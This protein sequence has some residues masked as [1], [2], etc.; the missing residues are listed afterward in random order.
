[1][2]INKEKKA[3]LL[4]LISTLF[5]KGIAFLTVPI[6]TRLLTTSD[7]GVTT[8][9]MSWVDIFTVILSFALYMS[10][11]TAFIDYKDKKNE[12]LNTIVTFT[13]CVSCVFCFIV[14]MLKNI[15][16]LLI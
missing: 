13:I 8:T 6:F 10:I 14:I 16:I 5:N 15:K 7:Y 2:K 3:S 11:R 1:M 12:F 4:Y 9:Y